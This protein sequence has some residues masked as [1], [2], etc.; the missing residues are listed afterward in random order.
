MKAIDHIGFVPTN[1]NL[2]IDKWIHK[3]DDALYSLKNGMRK[4][5]W[6][7]HREPDF[8]ERHVLDQNLGPAIRRMSW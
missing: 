6:L 2:T 1:V 7:A 3:A 4:L 5:A 8:C